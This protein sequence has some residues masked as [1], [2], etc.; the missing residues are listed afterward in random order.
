[1]LIGTNPKTAAYLTTPQ[2]RTMFSMWCLMSAPLLI[3]SS[4][5]QLNK[6]D[7]E[8][9]TNTELIAVDQDPLGKQG[10]RL[11]GSN[12]DFKNSF[13]NVWGKV[14]SDTSRV[15]IF[16]NNGPTAANIT[17]D[18][19][20]FAAIGIPSTETFIVRDLWLHQ[21]I[22][23]MAGGTYTALVPPNGASVTLKFFDALNIISSNK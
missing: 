2:S 12:L 23:K 17:C 1:M 11:V 21:N 10:Y 14:L 8:T 16:L 22:G 9:F 13:V 15:L 20:C 6:D 4:I 5:L 3:G 7:Y 19:S 18:G